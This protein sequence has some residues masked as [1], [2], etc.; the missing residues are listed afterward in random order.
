MV[1]DIGTLIEAEGTYTVNV[2][3][4]QPDTGAPVATGTFGV[5]GTVPIPE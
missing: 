1:T 3:G 5:K 2:G 4:G